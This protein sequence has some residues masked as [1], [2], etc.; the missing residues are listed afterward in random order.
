MEQALRLPGALLF[1]SL[2]SRLLASDNRLSPAK[3][4]RQTLFES[5][6]MVWRQ[7][8]LGIDDKAH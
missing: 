4:Q 8:R 6:L 7:L 1:S 2:L 5:V 3:P